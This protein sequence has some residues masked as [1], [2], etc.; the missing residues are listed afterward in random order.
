MSFLQGLGSTLRQFRRP[1][2]WLGIWLLGWVLCA[3]LSLIHPP[4]IEIPITYADKFE[5]FLAYAA[6]SA[7]SV[8]IFAKPRSHWKAAL[9]LVL[10][11]IVMELA[12]GAFTTYRTMDAWDALADALGVI[13]GQL[14]SLARAQS[15]LL[16]FD[17]R[18]FPKGTS[19]RP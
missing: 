8:L 6:L 1:G 17:K 16:R 10:L 13:F 4:Q 3:T 18:L 12:Q 9:A 5:H 14:L 11:G 7:W 2:L 19:F 15:L